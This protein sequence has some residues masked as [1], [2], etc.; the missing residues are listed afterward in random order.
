VKNS[1]D[2]NLLLEV[3]NW[4]PDKINP[5]KIKKDDYRGCLIRM[6][7]APPSPETAQNIAKSIQ[8]G[9]LDGPSS[10]WRK[11]LRDGQA[12]I[13]SQ[14]LNILEP[15]PVNRSNYGLPSARAFSIGILFK[16]LW[17][18]HW[19]QGLFLDIGQSKQISAEEKGA[20]VSFEIDG[21]TFN[22]YE[23][24]GFTS[25]EGYSGFVQRLYW[26]IYNVIINGE[27]SRIRV[28]QYKPCGS[29]FVAK[30]TRK[31]GSHC[32]ITCRTR[33][34][35]ESRT[36]KFHNRYEVSRNEA[37]DRAK[38]K[39]RALIERIDIDSALRKVL[40]GKDPP[41]GAVRKFKQFVRDYRSELSKAK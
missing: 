38:T 34:S 2:A 6:L 7:A 37:Y 17:S 15:K 5:S 14:L 26:I 41:R 16:M 9:D 31:P 32:S 4:N 13:R 10:H 35:N 30:R 3:L 23:R 33:S 39:F 24:V 11:Q 28:C 25:N 20:R 29:L 40:N 8:R 27:I 12:E 1:I 36:E 22:V 18:M 21:E 19:I